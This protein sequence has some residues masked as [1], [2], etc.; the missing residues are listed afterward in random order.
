MAPGEDEPGKGDEIG[1]RE[2]PAKQKEKGKLRK[3]WKE[4][5]EED[6]AEKN[7]P[8]WRRRAADRNEW[9]KIIK[10]WA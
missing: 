8:N 5:V 9:K 7:V 2:N 6:L 1:G 4:G 10:L 3:R